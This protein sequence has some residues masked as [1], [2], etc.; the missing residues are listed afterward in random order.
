[1]IWSND[2]RLRSKKA[3]YNLVCSRH[4]LFFFCCN[5]WLWPVVSIL[6]RTI[7]VH[8]MPHTRER[9]KGER[10]KRGAVTFM[11]HL[12]GLTTINVYY[13]CQ[14]MV[15]CYLPHLHIINVCK[16]AVKVKQTEWAIH[17]LKTRSDCLYVMLQTRQSYHKECFSFASNDITHNILQSIWISPGWYWRLN[18]K[19][20]MGYALY[21]QSTNKL[22][23]TY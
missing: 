11:W 6:H 19:L 4:I 21:H 17:H 2:L 8:K 12:V 18:K 7:I 23:T 3:F 20:K 22:I 10:R 13:Y 14:E 5:T 9:K 15:M 1:M 16:K